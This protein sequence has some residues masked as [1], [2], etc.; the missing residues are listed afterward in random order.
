SN[1]DLK[2]TKPAKTVIATALCS[3]YEVNAASAKDRYYGQIID[4]TGVVSGVFSS[5]V[6]LLGNIGGVHHVVCFFSSKYAEEVKQVRQG[7]QV[8]IRGK[9]GA[10]LGS[11]PPY[12]TVFSCTL[13]D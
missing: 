11:N 13:A 5:E 2:K 9:C 10:L 3:E 12:L 8:K 6:Q 7:E 4:I 1:A